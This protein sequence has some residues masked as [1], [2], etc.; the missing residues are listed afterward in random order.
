MLRPPTFAALARTLE[1]AKDAGEPYQV[2]HFDGHGAW[3][4]AERA[5]AENP[6]RGLSRTM[7][8]LVSP[9]R[10]GTH[11]F[12][13]FEDPRGGGSQQLVDGPALGG[14]LAGAGVP[15]LVLNACRSAHSDL[16]TEPETVA[17]ELDAHQRVRAY[18]SLAQEVM[19]AGVAGVA[20]FSG[21]V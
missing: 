2:V 16:V 10:P 15:V 1:E 12:L 8:S 19:D 7:F 14:L 11:G 18:G 13:V 5:T 9:A 20:R 6:A 21:E 4:D 3:L 17:R